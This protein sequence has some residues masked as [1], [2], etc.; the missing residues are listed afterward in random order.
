[1]AQLVINVGTAENSGDGDT[2]R[3]ALIKTNTNFT[4]L[5][6]DSVV[7]SNLTFSGS[8]VASESNQ[9]IIFNPN[10]TGKVN[11]HNAY[12]FPS[13][14]GSTNQVL[15]T[16]GDG[17]I[18]FQDASVSATSTTVALTA[19]NSTDANMFISFVDSATGNETIRTDTGLRYNPSSGAITATSFTSDGAQG[20]TVRDNL[21]STASSNADIQISPHGLGKVVIQN[22]S[23][24]GEQGIITTDSSNQDLKLT[25]NGTGKVVITSLEVADGIITSSDSS[26][27]TI[28]DSLDVNG[29]LSVNGTITTDDASNLLLNTNGGTNSGKIEI[30]DASNGDITIETDGNGDILLK[31]GGQ[32]GIGAVSSPDTDL[33]IKKPNRY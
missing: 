6:T 11:F 22:M 2:L 12:Q 8:T 14:D 15:M 24:D 27:I 18:T 10:G 4:E 17:T 16:D 31:A 7:S 20:I 21:I 19:T 25:P 32:V 3:A 5:F 23:I 29:T 1:M 9:D 30:V 33:H 28:N 26:A 13:A